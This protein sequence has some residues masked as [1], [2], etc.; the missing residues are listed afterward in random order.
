MVGMLYLPKVHEV[1]LYQKGIPTQSIQ[2]SGRR[3]YN[4]EA[5]RL[6]FICST[7]Q[8]DNPDGKLPRAFQAVT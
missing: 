2:D 1:N 4:A 5:V 7:C 8:C 3:T 6:T